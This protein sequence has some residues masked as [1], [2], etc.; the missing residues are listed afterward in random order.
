M[1][2]ITNVAI[3]LF[4]EFETL[5]VFG[6][7]EIFGS[8]DNYKTSFYSLKGGSKKSSQGY[9]IK[10][11]AL[12][13]LNDNLDIF[14]IPG[15]FGTRTEVSNQ[16]LIIEIKR[17]SEL[18]TH[19]LTV[20]TGSALLAVTGLLDNL[21]ATT[22]KNAYNWVI[23]NRSQVKWDNDARWTKD[24]KYYCS[25]G[26]SAGIDMTLHFISDTIGSEIAEKIASDCEY[27]WII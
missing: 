20:C 5:D 26:V 3:L 10:T 2:K 7:V 27:N 24:G 16:Q 4:D 9:S 14:L 25:A 13:C 19:V 18:S 22:N 6:P 21:K 1:G 8:V 23:S 17:V 15:G 11:T 12:S